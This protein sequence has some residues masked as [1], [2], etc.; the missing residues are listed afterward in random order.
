MAWCLEVVTALVI[1]PVTLLR[2]GVLTKLFD[3]I[4]TTVQGASWI[5]WNSFRRWRFRKGY[6]P[7]EYDFECRSVLVV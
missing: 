4:C 3:I 6:D 7:L 1:L 2:P 5:F